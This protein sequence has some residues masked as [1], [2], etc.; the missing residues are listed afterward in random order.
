M[1]TNYIRFMSLARRV[2]EAWSYQ[3]TGEETIAFCF[4][5]FTMSLSNGGDNLLR[6]KDVFPVKH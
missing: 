4:A 6:P 5:G 1:L 2:T 3:R